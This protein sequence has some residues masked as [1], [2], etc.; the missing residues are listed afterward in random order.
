MGDTL[1]GNSLNKENFFPSLRRKLFCDFKISI[2]WGGEV[3][4]VEMLR[5]QSM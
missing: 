3:I 1:L 2:D 5:D 4:P